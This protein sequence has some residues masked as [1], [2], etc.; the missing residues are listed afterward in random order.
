MEID[1]PLAQNVI[2]P[3]AKIVFI[4]LVLSAAAA[5]TTD[6]AIQEESFCVWIGNLHFRNQNIIDTK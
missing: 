3:L 5:A 2:A 6:A 1:L 4:P